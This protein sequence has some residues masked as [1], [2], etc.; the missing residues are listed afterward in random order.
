MKKPCKGE[1]ALKK[2]TKVEA[3]VKNLDK[4]VKALKKRK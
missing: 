4:K 3:R 1:K 2:V